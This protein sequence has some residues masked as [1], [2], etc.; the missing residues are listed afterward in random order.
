MTALEQ[1]FAGNQGAFGSFTFTDPW[2]GHAYPNCSLETDGLD[3]TTTAEMNGM[4]SLTVVEG[5]G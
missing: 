1:F 5:R 4:T 2:D 3:L